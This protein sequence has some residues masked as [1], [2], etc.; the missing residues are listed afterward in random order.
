MKKE[1]VK[2][3]RKFLA[4]LKNEWNSMPLFQGESLSKLDWMVTLLI[5]LALF[6]SCAHSDIKLTGN[7]S[8]LMYEHSDILF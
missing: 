2:K 1:G 5:L 4:G 6:F 3:N 7:R 8:F